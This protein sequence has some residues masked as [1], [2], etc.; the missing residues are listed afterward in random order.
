L[1]SVVE[2]TYISYLVICRKL[3]KLG[4]RAGGNIRGKERADWRHGR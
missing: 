2:E 4:F 3:M 1:F